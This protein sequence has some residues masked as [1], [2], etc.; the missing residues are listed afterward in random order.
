MCKWLISACVDIVEISI[1]GVGHFWDFEKGLPLMHAAYL[2]QVMHILCLI[3]KCQYTL[4][5]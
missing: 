2:V 3:L 5:I 4:I 1:T